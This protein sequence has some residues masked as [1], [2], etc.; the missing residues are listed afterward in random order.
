MT[1]YSATASGQGG[2]RHCF[3]MSLPQALLVDLRSLPRPDNCSLLL[4][5]LEVNICPRSVFNIQSGEFYDSRLSALF[6]FCPIPKSAG[7][8]GSLCPNPRPWITSSVKLADWFESPI[9][10]N[11]AYKVQIYFCIVSLRSHNGGPILGWTNWQVLAPALHPG[12][13]C[14]QAAQGPL[15]Q[16]RGEVTRGF[17]CLPGSQ[18]GRLIAPVHMVRR[19]QPLRVKPSAL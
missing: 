11:S 2:G 6:V 14:G 15:H 5:R 18:P 16:T 3:S 13:P 19:T 10:L 1:I 4:H 8:H 9:Q 17:S 12:D 7:F